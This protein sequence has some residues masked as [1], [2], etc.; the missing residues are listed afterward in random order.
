MLWKKKSTKPF[1][2]LSLILLSLFSSSSSIHLTFILL[3][4]HF[5]HSW[6]FFVLV[7]FFRC[8]FFTHIRYNGFLP[9][10]DKGRRRSKFVLYKRPEANG[11]RRS[12]HYIVQ[13]PQ[14][15]KAILDANQH[16]ISYTLSRNQAVIV[17]YKEDAD[18]DMFQVRT[19]IHSTHTAEYVY[20]F[21]RYKLFGDKRNL[22]QTTVYRSVCLQFIK[23]YNSPHPCVSKCANT[24]IISIAL[25]NIE[26]TVVCV[27]D[28]RVMHDWMCMAKFQVEN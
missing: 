18:T 5:F 20:T 27:D 21:M 14:T 19:R 17:E 26:T 15:S 6:F 10:G 22:G 12:R 7:L 11:V 23:L 25:W 4:L 28:T 24:K 1:L 3:L 9:Q 2:S 8:S 13:S 16:S